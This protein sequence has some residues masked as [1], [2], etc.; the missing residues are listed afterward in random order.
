MFLLRMRAL[1]LRPHGVQGTVVVLSYDEPLAYHF[2]SYYKYYTVIFGVSRGACT[3]SQRKP[4]D[5]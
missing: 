2:P 3:Y 5:H 4:H 1:S